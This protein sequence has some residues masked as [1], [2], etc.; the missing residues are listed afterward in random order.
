MG[1]KQAKAADAKDPA[2]QDPGSGASS[3]YTVL[4]RRYRPRDFDGLVGQDPIA[5]TLRNAVASKRLAHAYLFSGSRGVGKTSMA[6]I[7][8]KAI[9]A[10]GDLEQADEI[11]EAILRGD[12]LDVIEIDGASNRGI[13]EAKD[14]IAAAVLSPARCP[15]KIY[16][17]DEV[18]MLTREAF[19]ALL[20]TMEEPP[21]HVKFIL[22]TTEPHKVPATIR[23]RCQQFDFRL[24]ST[25]EIAGQLRKILED[26]RM[27]ADEQ[28]VAQVARLGRGS[29]RDALSLLDR[30]LAAGEQK[31]TTD[32]L[33]QMLGLPDQALAARLVDAIA[34]SDPPKALEAGAALLDRGAS[35]EQALEMLIEHLR[36]LLLVA[37][38]GPKSELIELSEDARRGA[39][40]Q[41]R[42]F[43]APGLVHMIALADAVARGTRD[44]ALKRALFDAAVVRMCLTEQL[45]DV[46]ALLG[47]DR[48]AASAA[49]ASKKKEAVTRGPKPP[50]AHIVE[51]KTAPLPPG[52]PGAELWASVQ[53]LA[54]EMPAD[55][56]RLEHLVFESFDGRRLR[57]AVDTPD[58]GLGRWLATQAEPVAEMVRRATS[59]EVVVEIDTSAAESADGPQAVRDRIE[60]AQQSPLVRRAME[61]FD[62][63]VVDVQESAAPGPGP[64]AAGSAEH[65]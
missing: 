7:L 22:C 63:T 17:I 28:V 19:N 31:L 6:R 62:A 49:G 43:D 38:C 25:A 27:S 40:E 50:P 30:L 13:N 33:E 60:E 21:R 61:I 23:S 51:A 65:V 18:H 46:A 48:P 15:K 2:A 44:P 58:A 45:A 14:L 20:K 37:T 8:A 35:V 34:D 5:K 39:V 26:E 59:R 32:L 57:L 1:S 3:S 41:A 4:A 53:A 47:G 16:I 29:M 42:R 55:R 52:A 10:T 54:A 64:D 12:D 24:L 11:A 9:N 56:A 36:N